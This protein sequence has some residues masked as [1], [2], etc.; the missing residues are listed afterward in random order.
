M[1]GRRFTSERIRRE[2]RTHFLLLALVWFTFLVV[3]VLLVSQISHMRDIR[4]AKISFVGNKNVATEALAPLVLS[5]I[6]GSYWRLFP[7]RNVFLVRTRILEQSL[8]SAYPRFKRVRVDRKNLTTLS[9]TIEEREPFAFW[10]TDTSTC[11]FLDRDGFVFAPAAQF[12]KSNSFVRYSGGAV[13]STTPIG[14]QFAERAVFGMLQ[15]FLTDLKNRLGLRAV[16]V[17]QEGNHWVI[18]VAPSGSVGIFSLLVTLAPSYEQALSDFETITSSPDFK[19]AVT[20]LS[21]LEYI[22]LRFG[23]KVFYKLKVSAE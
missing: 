8:E 5:E 2:R 14:S 12:L 1:I 20:S 11:Y 15:T 3:C 17:T 23:N 4:I 6:S 18:A 7:K 21:N 10:C 19:E 9:I 13:V 22:D 16:R